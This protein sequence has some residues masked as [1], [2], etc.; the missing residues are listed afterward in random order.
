MQAEERLDKAA[1]KDVTTKER[2]R[3]DEGKTETQK[4]AG[5]Y[6]GTPHSSTYTFPTFRLPTISVS[7]AVP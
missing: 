3:E 7:S 6:R 5:G 2:K 4:P 1:V